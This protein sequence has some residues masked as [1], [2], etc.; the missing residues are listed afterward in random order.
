MEN[1]KAVFFVV[2]VGIILSLLF[3]LIFGGKEEKQPTPAPTQNQ[4][5]NGETDSSRPDPLEAERKAQEQ[6]TEQDKKEIEGFIKEFLTKYLEYDPTKPTAHIESVKN[7][8]DPS[9]F[10][11]EFT[12]YK[13]PISD[14]RNRKL[15]K[16]HDLVITPM[17]NGYYQVE[18]TAE[19]ELTTTKG[20]FTQFS[21]FSCEVSKEDSGW[22]IKVLNY[23]SGDGEE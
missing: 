7:D 2:I 6:K 17:D 1:N 10:Q 14:W 23:Y 11:T 13:T 4:T 3:N 21:G 12:I 18:A 9:I 20:T 8:L 5:T 22:K 16:I 15:K 19:I